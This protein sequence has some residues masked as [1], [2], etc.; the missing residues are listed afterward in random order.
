MFHVFPILMP[1]A[2]ASGRVY[3]A[4]GALVSKQLAGGALGGTEAE[5]LRGA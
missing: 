2:D 1:W 4:V 5:A 3:R